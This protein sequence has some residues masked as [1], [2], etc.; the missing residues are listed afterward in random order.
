MSLK[1][2]IKTIASATRSI[3]MTP[4]SNNAEKMSQKNWKNEQKTVQAGYGPKWNDCE[5]NS[6]RVGD[7]FAFVMNAGS[8]E[9]TPC[10]IRLHRVVHI[11]PPNCT[12]PAPTSSTDIGVWTPDKTGRNILNLSV[13]YHTTD[14]ET[15][16]EILGWNAYQNKQTADGVRI[17]T[18]LQRTSRTSLK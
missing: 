3:T 11:D 17:R 9:D 2:Q 15:F 6:T 5:Q 7:L 4:I 16:C 1:T 18:P 12:R 14:W 8:R 10:E 13:E